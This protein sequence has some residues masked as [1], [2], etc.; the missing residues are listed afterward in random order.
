MPLSD[1][2]P[3]KMPEALNIGSKRF[4]SKGKILEVGTAGF[5]VCHAKLRKPVLTFEHIHTW[6][7]R[8]TFDCAPIKSIRTTRCLYSRRSA[9]VS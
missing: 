8:Q 7:N 1:P 9:R 2:R 5:D 3:K 6:S 4:I